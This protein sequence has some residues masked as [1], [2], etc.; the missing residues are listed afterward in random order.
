MGTV[1]LWGLAGT[2]QLKRDALSWRQLIHLILQEMKENVAKNGGTG[3]PI[4][5]SDQNHSWVIKCPWA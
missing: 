3:G 4:L 2:Q 1:G 5:G